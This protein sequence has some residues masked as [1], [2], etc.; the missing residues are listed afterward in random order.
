VDGRLDVYH[1]P[2]MHPDPGKYDIAGKGL[3]HMVERPLKMHFL[4][5]LKREFRLIL[6]LKIFTAALSS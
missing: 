2:G 5:L 6:I 1:Q 3:A 4:R